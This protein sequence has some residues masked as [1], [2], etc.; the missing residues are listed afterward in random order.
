MKIKLAGF[1]ALA[2]AAAMG[3]APIAVADGDLMYPVGVGI[4]LSPMSQQNAVRKA[5]NYLDYTAFSRQGLIN[6]LEY[7]NFST[8]DAIFAVDH[9][10]VD[11]NEQAVKKAKKYL[12]YTAFSRGGLINQLEYDGFTHASAGGIWSSRHRALAL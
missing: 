5:E 9:I 3:L 12:D 1:A 11:W 2:T 10:T 4:A 7:D 6:Q 8:E